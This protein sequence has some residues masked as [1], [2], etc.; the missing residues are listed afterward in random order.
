MCFRPGQASLAPIEC[1]HCGESITPPGMAYPKNCPFCKEDISDYV[2]SVSADGPSVVKPAA[3]PSK[4]AAPAA[5]N[6]PPAPQK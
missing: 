5:P 4:P 3:P 2:A 1:P 6:V